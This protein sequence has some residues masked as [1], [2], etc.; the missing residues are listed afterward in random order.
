M[1]I[2][3]FCRGIHLP[4][5]AA[6]DLTGRFTEPDTYRNMKHLFYQNYERF[7]ETILNDKEPALW[8]LYYFAHFSCEAYKEYE[9]RGLSDQL[10]WDT[11]S[12]LTIWCENCRRDYGVYGLMEYEWLWRHVKLCLFRLGRLQFEH[13]TAP[14]DINAAGHFIPA[15]TA[16]LNVHIPQGSPADP[17]A[18][19]DSF[20]KARAMFPE[21]HY[22]LCESWMLYP[23]L[24]AVMKETANTI[25]FQK[26]FTVFET[27]EHDRDAERR[28]FDRLSGN[29]A[30]YPADTPFQQR[31]RA[32]LLEGH[33]LGSASGLLYLE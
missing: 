9:L 26:R 19:D 20:S 10:Y 4:E 30:D 24:S 11:F 25:L 7:T 28:I 15:G 14:H 31:V 21:N 29:P 2:K 13:I 3:E 33:V 12:D 23:G 17:E 1:N 16:L 32:Y 8:F 5:E 22:F 27:N 18:C 6:A